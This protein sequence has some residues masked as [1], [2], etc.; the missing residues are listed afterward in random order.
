MHAA[1]PTSWFGRRRQ[2]LRQVYKRSVA[3]LSDHWLVNRL[4]CGALLFVIFWLV[5]WGHMDSDFGWHLASGNY[6]R[7]HGIPRHDVFTYTARNFPWIDHEWGNDVIVSLLYGLGGYGLLAVLYGLLWTAALLLVGWRARLVTLLIA[8]SAMLPY[9]GI[10]PVAWTVCLLAVVVRVLQSQ[11]Q[12]WKWALPLLFIPWAN[13]HAGFVT[14]LAVIAWFTLRERKRYLVYILLLCS[15][16]TFVNAYGPRLYVEIARTLFD[17]ELHSQITEWSRFTI[18]EPSWVFVFLWASG[19]LLFVGW[20][21]QRWFRLSSLLLLLAL[22]ATRNVPLFVIGGLQELDSYLQQAWRAIPKRLEPL[23]KL[24][25]L[26]MMACGTLLVLYNVFYVLPLANR[27]ANYPVQAVAYLRSHESQ[28]CEGGNLFNAYD[29]GGYLIWELPSQPV[30]IDGRMPSWRDPD[31]QKYLNRYYQLTNDQIP[32]QAEFKHY[33]IRCALLDTTSQSAPLVRE[34][35]KNNWQ[36]VLKAN[37]SLLLL[38][39]D[40]EPGGRGGI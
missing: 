2:D 29:Y 1:K 20:Q 14:G 13:L 21:P 11:R 17:P 25:L 8:A 40:N 26:T 6:F 4:L 15:L 35:E 24:V 28:G 10:R 3:W 38:A 27:Q 30:Y 31:G 37:N 9:A 18:Y 32:Y 5:C 39:P 23:Q 19:S 36:V 7:A 22:S 34:L 12:R 33:D 16:A